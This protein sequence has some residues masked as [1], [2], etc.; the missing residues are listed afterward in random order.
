MYPFVCSHACVTGSY[1]LGECFGETWVRVSEKGALA[2]WGSSINTEWG[3]DDIIER[4][5]FDAWWN[6][7]LDKIGQMTDKGMY[8][9]YMQYGSYMTKFIESYNVMGDASVK[10]WSDDPFVPEHDI[11]V[12]NIVVDDYVAHGETQT[13]SAK[14]RNVGNNT[15]A[16]IFVDFKI[17]DS[18]IDTTTVA[19]L[20][21]MQSEIVS[22]DWNPDYGT[23]LVAVESQLVPGEN[24]TD[25]NEAN[26]TVHV[27][28]APDIWVSPDSFDFNV[29]AGDS[30]SDDLIVGNEAW[31]ETDLI[32]DV[33]VS[34]GTSW[35]SV[36]PDT[37]SVPIDDTIVLNVSVDATGMTEGFYQGF[38]VISCNDLDEPTIVVPVNLSVVFANDVG[39]ISVNSPVGQQVPGS[40]VINA[41]VENFGSMGNTFDVNC[42]IYEAGGLTTED[43]ELDD[44]GYNHGDGPGPGSIDDWEWGAP[45]SGPNNAHSGSNVWATNLDGDHSNSADSVL[46]SMAVN[47][48]MY[49][50]MPELTFWHWYDHTTYDCG[51]VKI[52]T[53]GGMTWS[54]IYP[55]GGY[56]GTATSGN[57]GIPGEPAYTDV[58]GGWLQARFNLSA[59]ESQTVMFRWHFG[60]TSTTTH[61]GWYIDDVELSSSL[62]RGP[63]D[64]IY[65]STETIYLP[66]YST[67]FVEF[68]PVWTVT[69]YSYYVIDVST[70]L[71]GDEDT[72]NDD[73]MG[74]VQI[75]AAPQGHISTLVDGWNFVSLPFNQSMFKNNL[76]INYLGVDYNWEDAVGMG[77]IS[78]F[79]FGW[80][81][82]G[83]A[84]E[85]ADPVMPGYG[86]WV[87][88]YENCVLEAPVFNINFDGYVTSL[89]ENW[90]VVGLPNNIPEDK[91]NINVNYGGTD[92]TWTDAVTG[93]IIDGNLFGWDRITQNY[94]F[95]DTFECGFC[96]WLYSYYDCNLLTP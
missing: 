66:E 61:P 67:G 32:F 1:E 52:S 21:P 38:L 48:G 60:S 15:E 23:Y 75:L 73:T 62:I 45:T 28:P 3:P 72:S 16:G 26:K 78:D 34:G 81:R 30:D 95:S 13:V 10:I 90:N 8:D 68:S 69:N 88:S 42:S 84:Y 47:L 11:A 44:G 46:D 89:K 41:T 76:I 14:V 9:S 35:L 59:Y 94:V 56:T 91:L 12:E 57:M 80:N 22:F 49:A 29:N 40:Y 55:D 79:I 65:S 36:N 87:Y 6:L 77:C 54:I 86:Y 4:R 82:A 25:N 64:L 51:N 74:V 85:F 83:Q 31:A 50:P 18:V 43:F 70:V 37:G 71:A 17:N 20:D 19:L 24:I 39:A 2:F 96:Y 5:V 27:I 93:G 53:D 92:Y 63:G 7:S 33:S 58:S